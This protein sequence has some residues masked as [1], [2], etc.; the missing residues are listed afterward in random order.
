MRFDFREAE[1]ID[2]LRLLAQAAGW[3][4]TTSPDVGGKLTI[5]FA[6]QDWHEALAVVAMAAGL[7]VRDTGEVI[8]VETAQAGIDHWNRV[9]AL[10]ESADEAAPVEI[11]AWTL[12][13]ADAST[14]AAYLD[15]SEATVGGGNSLLSKRGVALADPAAN[16]LF[17][18]DTAEHLRRIGPV[19][20]AL[21]ILPTQVMIESEIIETSTETGRDLGIQW[22][23][24]ARFGSA[25]TS[26]ESSVRRGEVAGDGVGEAPSG[27]PWIA[28]FPVDVGAAAGSAVGLS[29]GQPDDAH[30]LALRLSALEREG[31]VRVVSR[32][33]VVTT[34]SVAATI[35]SLTVI[36][37][38]LPSTDT[39]VRTD[40]SA[41]IA[42][43]AAT[44]KIETGIV[45]VVTPRVTA[46][47][48]VVLDLFIKSSQADFSRV[49]DGIPTETSREATSRVVVADGETVVIGGIYADTSD[50]LSSGVPFLRSVPGIGWLFRGS[51]RS[52]RR[53]DLL[54]F[55]TPHIL[56]R[57][58]AHS[59]GD[60]G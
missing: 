46:D 20:D 60:Q 35:K 31:R 26:G 19:I 21:D 6:A 43:S 37:V 38:K 28:G 16:R 40:G 42:P 14:V 54:V 53:E 13:Y 52:R 50:R 58:D 23:Y 8:R 24:R 9:R 34:T 45:L 32:P 11:A 48:G 12:Q 3:Q 47:G 25:E 49:V 33:R 7:H 44:E 29:W 4:L 5:R 56:G 10:R 36:R 2:V 22:G 41:S 17:V 30:A 55:I 39:L 57:V 15:G 27:I 1:L 18:A 59:D 51:E